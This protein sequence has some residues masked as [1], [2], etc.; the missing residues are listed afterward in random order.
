MERK[1]ERGERRDEW[2]VERERDVPRDAR[3]RERERERETADERERETHARRMARACPN[4]G[5]MHE[6]ETASPDA[7]RRR[8]AGA[9]GSKS[10]LTHE[11][12]SDTE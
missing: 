9:R 3:E 10:S 4:I 5:D 2:H 12:H 1:R 6:S 8:L 11:D 7:S